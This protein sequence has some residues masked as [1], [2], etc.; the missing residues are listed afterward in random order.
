MSTPVALR[1][2]SFRAAIDNMPEPQPKSENVPAPERQ[3]AQPFEAERGGRMRAGAE[4][5][6]GIETHDDG[7]VRHV[8]TVR[9]H[10]Q[11]CA[12]LHRPRSP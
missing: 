5:K 1:A 9:R 12:E 4:G 7:T 3:S 10:P 2:P 6:A 8:R 11:F